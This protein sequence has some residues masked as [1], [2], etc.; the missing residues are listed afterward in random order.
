ML[1]YVL[2][3]VPANSHSV[4]PYLL[5]LCTELCRFYPALCRNHPALPF[6]ANEQ[7]LLLQTLVQAVRHQAPLPGTYSLTSSVPITSFTNL[8]LGPCPFHKLCI[9]PK[10]IPQNHSLS[11]FMVT[12]DT[13]W[14]AIKCWRLSI[15]WICSCVEY[16]VGPSL[17]G[18]CL[19]RSFQLC[20]SYIFSALG[21]WIQGSW[22][23]FTNIVS[24]PP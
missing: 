13:Y 23:I 8:C 3:D 6:L 5:L 16:S 11:T 22:S 4:Q 9:S 15:R 21:M 2:T 12:H 24:C 20:L 17:Q 7:E 14:K 18:S 10:C 1:L 19:H